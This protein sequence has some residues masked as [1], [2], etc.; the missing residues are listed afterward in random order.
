MPVRLSFRLGSFWTMTRC[1]SAEEGG[2]FIR[3]I[4]RFLPDCMAQQ[5]TPEGSYILLNQAQFMMV[6]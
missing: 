1:R 6:K 3:N 5:T 2:W 4:G